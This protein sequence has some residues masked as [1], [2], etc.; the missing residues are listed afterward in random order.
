M[1][2]WGWITPWLLVGL[3]AGCAA[4]LTREEL[5]EIERVGIVNSFPPHP[6]Y[7]HIGTTIFNNSNELV[8]EGEYHTYLV[9][10]LSEL[11]RGRGYTPVPMAADAG[12]D[13]QVDLV[14]EIIPRDVYEMVETY[15]Y[16]F[17]QRSFLG[18]VAYTK[19]YVALNLRSTLGARSTCESCNGQS[20]SSLPVTGQ[21][22]RSWTALSA[23]QRQ[24]FREILMT[25]IRRALEKAFAKIGL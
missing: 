13:G 12:A 8:E 22:P 21:L 25:D 1:K 7:T 20:L 23:A 15:G 4:P 5:A 14:I 11:L 2:A 10:V 16:G 6:N 19:S 17:Y 9:E 24:R 3:L 18:A